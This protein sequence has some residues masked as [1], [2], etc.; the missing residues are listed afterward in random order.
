[1]LYDYIALIVFAVLAFIV[2]LGL[3]LGSKLLTRRSP[4][5][6]VKNAPWESGEEA[7]GRA[8]DVE[9]EYLP[10]FSL[11]LP[12]EIITGMVLVWSVV[13]YG[14]GLVVGVEVIVLAIAAG[15]AAGFGY[16]TIVR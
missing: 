2:P 11:F 7:V 15:T 5:N 12:F 8:R 4:G 16:R 6:P 3:I 9:N 1:M 13:A 14:V 10:F